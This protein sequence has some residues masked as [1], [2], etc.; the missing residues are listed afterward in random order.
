LGWE[1]QG[2]GE[3]DWGVGK[4][5]GEKHRVRRGGGNCQ[6]KNGT[7]NESKRGTD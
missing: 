7:R 4:K 1:V 2:K 6:K 3:L 5:K